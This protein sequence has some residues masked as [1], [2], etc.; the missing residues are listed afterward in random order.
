MAQVTGLNNIIAGNVPDAN[1]HR[2]NFQIIKEQY[3]FHDKNKTLVHGIQSGDE[4]TSLEYIGEE[5]NKLSFIGSVIAIWDSKDTTVPALDT[6]TW[7]IMDGSEL[8]ESAKTIFGTDYAPDMTEAYV[9]T[10]QTCSESVSGS[11]ILYLNH[12][13]HLFSHYH[14]ISHEHSYSSSH[15]TGGIVL[16]NIG[17]GDGDNLYGGLS[18]YPG[19]FTVS[20][21]TDDFNINTMASSSRTFYPLKGYA[22]SI[23]TATG[24]T[25][26]LSTTVSSSSS[27]GVGVASKDLDINHKPMSIKV[28]YYLRYN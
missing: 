27:T 10:N 12:S 14:S 7:L 28:R 13:G 20:E 22:T 3:N 5:K 15:A 8:P 19:S 25:S 26:N 2:E 11:N 4:L 21:R 23:S 1:S 24:T 6:D 9:C 17:V 16:F 18:A